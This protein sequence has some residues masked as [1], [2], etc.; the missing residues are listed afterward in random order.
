MNKPDKHHKAV[1]D[2][3]TQERWG[4]SEKGE[5]PAWQRSLA[6]KPVTDK[7]TDLTGT[8]SDNG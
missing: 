7:R 8:R 1:W 5:E 6:S 4:E 2:R 3:N